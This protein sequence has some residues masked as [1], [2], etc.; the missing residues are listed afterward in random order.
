MQEDQETKNAQNPK[1][2]ATPLKSKPN[3]N[4][5]PFYPTT[6]M[7]AM[8]LKETDKEGK[9]SL[10]GKKSHSGSSSNLEEIFSPVANLEMK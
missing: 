2:S 7:E 10:N 3:Q 4:F 5:E 6:E 8:D 1:K 9:P